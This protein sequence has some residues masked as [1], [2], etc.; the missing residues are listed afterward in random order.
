[1][2]LIP[3]HVGEYFDF[4]L[5]VPSLSPISALSLKI[6]FLTFFNSEK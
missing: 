3:L 4:I 6:E 1:M 2:E 5:P